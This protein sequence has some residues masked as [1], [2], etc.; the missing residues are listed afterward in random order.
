MLTLDNLRSFSINATSL[1]HI[2][3]LSSCHALETLNFQQLRLYDGGLPMWIGSLPNIR[4]VNA[5]GIQI[6]YKEQEIVLEWKKRFT[7]FVDHIK[8]K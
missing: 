1:S 3:D 2:P 6:P 5:S 7:I 8:L 4:K